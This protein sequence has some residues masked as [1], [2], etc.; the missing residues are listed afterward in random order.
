[1][2]ISPTPA[3]GGS[4]GEVL[5]LVRSSGGLTRAE[6]MHRTGLARSTVTQRLHALVELGLVEA[7]GA[8]STGGRP[9]SRF[10]F[11]PEAG[12]LLVAD[13][14]ATGVR[15]AVTDLDGTV[16]AEV[17]RPLDI[18]SGP[19][20][21]LTTIDRLFDGLLQRAH[22]SPARLLG[23][24]LGVPGPVDFE[25]GE[26]VTP[27]IMS[28]WDQ[29]DI[30]SWFAPR[31]PC[32]VIVENDAN[33]MAVG[34]HRMAHADV[35][36]LIM[37]KIS[38]GIGAGIIAGGRLFRGFDGAAGD[39]GHVQLSGPEAVGP[40]PVCRCG[41]HGCVEAYAGGWA[42]VRDLR[43]LGRD[44]SSV[45]DIVALVRAADPEAVAATRRAGRI[46]GAGL[47]DAVSLLNPAVVVLGGALTSA[48]EHLFAGVRET[49]YARSLPLATRRLSIVG[50]SQGQHAGLAG[51][52]VTLN[53]HLLDPSRIEEMLGPMV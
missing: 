12:A 33:A 30:R 17:E 24:G 4:A 35:D 14:G 6:V 11:R 16:L 39:L 7:S 15:A 9:A 5:R 43:E 52:V 45:S 32:P 1:M 48:G 44:V 29:F 3:H 25:R 51:I 41:N 13:V 46:I 27:P 53:D 36:S 19:E 22:L 23:V 38:T 34:E 26:V 37:L 18:T 40:Q 10:V 8:S 21:C 20:S 42:L 50:A 47:S 2:S 31:R 28:G 49:V